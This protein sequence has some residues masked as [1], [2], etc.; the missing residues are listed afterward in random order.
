[1]Y[2][3]ILESNFNQ[4]SLNLKGFQISNYYF[5][6]IMISANY[7]SAKIMLTKLQTVKILLA[8]LPM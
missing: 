5:D 1:M 2:V 7:I 3:C 8:N 6:K 4:F